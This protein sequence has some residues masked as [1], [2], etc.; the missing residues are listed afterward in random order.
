MPPNLATEGFKTQPLW[1]HPFLL[2]PGKTKL[3]PWLNVRMPT[4]HFSETEAGTI[5]AY[6]AAIDKVPTPFIPTDVAAT[7]ESLKAGA[8]LFDKVQ[9]RKL[10]YRRQHSACGQG[11]R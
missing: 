6:F 2:D 7:A 10:P 1:L 11:S 8:E 4:F 5:G 3:R 9:V